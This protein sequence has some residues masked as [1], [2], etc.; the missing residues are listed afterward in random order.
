LAIVCA[1]TDHVALI[2]Y[3]IDEFELPIESADSRV[4]LT[5]LLPNLDRE[6]ERRRV[7]ELKTNDGMRNPGRAP[8]INR[9]VDTVDLRHA[10]G[11]RLPTRGIVGLGR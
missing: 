6:T 11:A 8:V 3:D 2:G 9:E 4:S 10:Y 7:G 5:K 1:Q